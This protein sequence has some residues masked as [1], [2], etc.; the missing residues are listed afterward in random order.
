MIVFM[1]TYIVMCSVSGGV[2]GSRRGPL[3]TGDGTVATFETLEAARL[4]AG[5]LQSKSQNAYGPARYM[6]WAEEQQS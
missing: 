4:R 2:T 3:K 5:E 1:T 6:Y